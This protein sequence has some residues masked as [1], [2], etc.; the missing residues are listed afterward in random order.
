MVRRGELIPVLPGVYRSAFWPESHLATLA[1]ICARNDTA[2]IG[3]T[4]AAKLWGFRRVPFGAIH[5]L[6]PHGNSPEL[7]IATVHRCRRIDP[8]DIVTRE[9]G[10]RLTSPP[11]T[12]FDAADLLGVSAARSVMEQIL[13]DELCTFGT[14]CDT[15]ARLAHPNRPG[16]RTMSLVIRSKPEWQRALQSDLEL[17]VLQEIERQRLP[18]PVTQCPID[19]PSGARIHLDFGWP[20]WKVGLE[21]DDPTWHAGA[22]ERHRDARRDRKAAVLGW[23]IPRLSKLDVRESLREGVADVASILRTRGWAA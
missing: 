2:V 14:I 1:A 21:V 3:F 18:A 17:R 13:N 20:S 4:T 16:S 15:F 23:Q 9:D 12:L 22:D 19:L 6:T 7:D 8:I 11:R 10:I 5:V